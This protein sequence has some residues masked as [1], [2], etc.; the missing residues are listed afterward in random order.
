MSHAKVPKLRY[1]FR[2]TRLLMDYLAATY[3]GRRWY[4]NVRVGAL[5][6]HALRPGMSE[7]EMRLLG[8][9]RRYA[10]AI[11]GPP[12]DVVVVETTIWKAVEKIG[13]LMEY[14][15]LVPETPELA[16]LRSYPLRGELVSPIPDQR[17]AD[18]CGRVGIRFVVFKVTWLDETIAA[19]GRRFRRAPLSETQTRFV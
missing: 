15:A 1:A 2:E 13:P 9:W 11:V 4:T 5:E 7:A 3:P 12:P 8:G 10:D 17:A 14:L 19:Y 6:P 18:I 16:E